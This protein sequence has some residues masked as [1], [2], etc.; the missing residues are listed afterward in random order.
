M[1]QKIAGIIVIALIL[2]TI[3]LRNGDQVQGFY[4]IREEGEV[5]YKLPESI[6]YTEFTSDEI[7]LPVGSTIKTDEYSS[8]HILLPDNSLIS[9]D[10]NTELTIDINEENVRI[11]Q[12]TGKS[13][14]RVETLSHGNS[15]DVRNTDTTASANG[16]IFGFGIDGETVMTNVEEGIV[17]LSIAESVVLLEEGDQGSIVEQNAIKQSTDNQFKQSRWYIR[18][19]LLDVIKRSGLDNIFLKDKLKKELQSTEVTETRYTPINEE[20]NDVIS[21]IDSN[22]NNSDICSETAN[23]PDYVTYSKYANFYLKFVENCID[24]V[25][26]T[27]ELESLSEIYSSIKL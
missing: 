24:N 19:K 6:H 12:L 9:I 1:I 8:A 11:E 10:E 13:W 23:F 2:S 27:K 17:A 21:R 15:Y 5:F 20:I 3:L 22:S 14:N 26:D 7:T 18:N 25:L 4:L 16:T